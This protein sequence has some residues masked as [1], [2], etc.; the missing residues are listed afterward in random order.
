MGIGLGIGIGIGMGGDAAVCIINE[1][2]YVSY[3]KKRQTDSVEMK[4]G[5]RI[6]ES[7]GQWPL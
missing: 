2:L 3:C 7:Q 6:K 1:C 5:R 4:D